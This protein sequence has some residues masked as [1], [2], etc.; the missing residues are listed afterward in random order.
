MNSINTNMSALNAQK[1]MQI[2]NNELSEAMTRLS[3]GLRIN[4]AADDAAGSAIASKMEAQVRSLDVAIRN[5]YDAIS[6]TQTAE[7]ALGEM[8]NILQR[9][10]ELSVQASNST[11]S[12]NDRSQLQA[13][14]D[15]LIA[16]VDAI[17]TKTHFNNVKLL[18]GSNAS[19]TF[20][21]GMN[22]SDALNVALESSGS[23]ALGLNGS[24]GVTT[25]TSERV[26]KLSYAASTILAADIKINGF[27]AL[28]TTF[29][30][31]LTSATVN[32]AKSYADAINA[33]TGVHGAEADAFNSLTSNPVGTFNMDGDISINSST[34]ATASSYTDLVSKINEAVSGVVATLNDDNSISL[35]NTDGDDIIIADGSSGT[36]AS[37]GFTAGTYTGFYSLTNLDGS[38]VTIEAGSSTN[39]YTSGTGV[40]ADVASFGFNEFSEAGKL[41]TNTVSGTA[42]SA[43]EIKIN[44]VLIGESVSGSAAHVAA[45]INELTSSH[46]VTADAQN[47]VNLDLDFE[48]RPSLATAFQVNGTGV[49]LR[50]ANNIADF[51]TSFNTAVIGDLRATAKSDGTV[52]ITSASGVDIVVS[53]TDN[54]FVIGATDIHG[55]SINT[56]LGN[57][58]IDHDGILSNAT[59]AV[60][61]AQ[62][63]S[64]GSLFGQVINSQII[65]TQQTTQA[66]NGSSFALTVTGKDADGNTITEALTG[67]NT[68]KDDEQVLGTQVFHTITKITANATMA[69][70]FDVGVYSTQTAEFDQDSLMTAT[71]VTAAGDLTLGG[72]LASSNLN[73]SVITIHS[74]TDQSG[75]SALT[76]TVTGKDAFGATITE[77]ITYN[78]ANII[79]TTPTIH[80]T[81]A[82]HTVSNIHV[83]GDTTSDVTIGTQQ[84]GDVVSAKGKMILSTDKGNP[85]K[86]EA[87]A[88]DHTTLNTA[89]GTTD[90]I[91]QKMGIQAQGQAFEVSGT[92]VDVN[93]I[94]GANA[95]LALIDNAIDKL[96]L[97]RSSF[98]AVENRIDASI[99]NLTTLKV[100]TQAAQSRIE[101]ADFAAETSR[102]TKSQIL[103]QAATSMLAQANASK[104]N[105][106]ALLQG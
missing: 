1:N 24:K 89:A 32:T 67:V 27:N 47:R 92:G 41:E 23:V 95:S 70:A 28:A 54:D 33:N 49:D 73:N 59:A 38:G 58:T 85:I 65:L 56:G 22:A 8:E 7:G 78:S 100:N 26:E 21:I 6:M 4:S 3:S 12:T 18:D 84:V 5:S 64:G 14:V 15:T 20:Q 35:S 16:E 53:N 79:D 69:N 82:F 90:V 29:N 105:L 71:D 44:D 76:Y 91:M 40:I 11:L 13:E 66:Y 60:T 77:A 51:V 83:S 34:V 57:G 102:M 50:T 87:V 17:A 86:V 55:T 104:Q 74:T 25:L 75:A 81:Q 52:D 31:N 45:A 9:V 80:G 2:Q 62:D 61:G 68:S 43:N 106:L 88:E 96:S 93:S 37:V 97:F 39:G 99:N 19:V 48:A 94:S 98:G 101:D 36:A 46:G 30:S 10:R 63:L 72:A 42:V 103:S